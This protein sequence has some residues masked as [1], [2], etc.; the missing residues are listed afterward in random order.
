M[1]DPIKDR[2]RYSKLIRVLQDALEKSA[3]ILGENVRAGAERR[4]TIKHPY[5]VYEYLCDLLDETVEARS[6]LD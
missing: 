2:D 5:E 4:V 1:S 6:R 3:E